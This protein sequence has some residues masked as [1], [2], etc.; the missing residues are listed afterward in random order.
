MSDM[1]GQRLKEINGAEGVD[2]TQAN[3]KE[4]IIYKELD[5]CKFLYTYMP[6]ADGSAAVFRDCKFLFCDMI[7]VDFQSAVF[8]SC[9]FQG[10]QLGESMFQGARFEN[11]T[12][13]ACSANTVNFKDVVFDGCVIKKSS[14]M[15]SKFHGSRV[16]AVCDVSMLLTAGARELPE[17]FK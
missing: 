5:D 11:C 6:Y 7:G 1:S 12:L 13:E 17:G 2:F 10:C 9:F 16:D 3:L 15:F 4:C 8:E 14:F